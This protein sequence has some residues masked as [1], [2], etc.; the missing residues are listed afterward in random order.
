M[1]KTGEFGTSEANLLS[2]V[3]AILGIHSGNAE[4]YRQ[5][6]ELLAGIVR[7]LTSAIDAKD[8]YTCG[9]SDRVA[10]VAVRLAEEL[11]CDAKTM[12]N[13]LPGGPAARRRQ[14]RHR[15][16]RAPQAGQAHAGGVRAHQDARRESA[17][18][19]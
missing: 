10:R 3:A 17:T 16:R 5:Q 18:A 8:P 2:S 12:R 1:R 6:A 13:D 11:G 9:H 7:A 15:R 19:S 14:D 4:L